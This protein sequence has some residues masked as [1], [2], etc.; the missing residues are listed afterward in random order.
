MKTKDFFTSI[1]CLLIILVAQQVSAISPLN[2]VYNS[3]LVMQIDSTIATKDLQA[4]QAKKSKLKILDV[5]LKKDFGA[6]PQLLPAATWHDPTKVDQW[7]KT[8]RLWSIV[9]M[10]TRLARV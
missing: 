2:P 6:D 9:Y 1:F 8:V 4:L 5:R 10:D 3:H 7:V